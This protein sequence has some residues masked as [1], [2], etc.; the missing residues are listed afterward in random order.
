MHRAV[1]TGCLSLGSPH[2]TNVKDDQEG[3]ATSVAT[4]SNTPNHPCSSTN[5]NMNTDSKIKYRRKKNKQHTTKYTL[6]LTAA[7]QEEGNLM[8]DDDD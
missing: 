8:R 5:L 3:S 2:R 4:A 6:I 7:E 1:Q